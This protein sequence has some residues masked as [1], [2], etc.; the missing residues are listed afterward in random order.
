M[1]NLSDFFGSS[2]GGSASFP[3]IFLSKSQTWV[4]PQDGNICIHVIG[5]GGGGRGHSN[6][7][8]SGAAGGYCKKNTLAVTTS[9]SFT[10][11][12]GAAGAGGAN[13]RGNGG[14]GGNGGNS[15]VAGTGLSAT[16]TANG[17]AGAAGVNGASAASGG[18]ASNGDVNNTG[19]AGAGPHGNGYGAAGG[20]AVGLT[21]TGQAGS[22]GNLDIPTAG[23]THIIG[24]LWSSTMGQ[25]AGG[26]A[27]RCIRRINGTGPSDAVNG[28]PLSGG[29]G[30]LFS[31][32]TEALVQ[33]GAGG[34]GAGGGGGENR[35]HQS[36]SLGGEGGEGIVVI[37]YIP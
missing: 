14:A 29:G 6:N 24:D 36:S 16:L 32:T 13:G 2:G 25:I 12:V 26:L 20:G 4:P 37:Q 9:G 21:G 28:G 7:T 17:G 35:A 19:G 34:I 30:V 18:T 10:V 8:G 3:T 33:G 27:G 1:S 15:T 23:E 31:T 11:V 5:A 22:I